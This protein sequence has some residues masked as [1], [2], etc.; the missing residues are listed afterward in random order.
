MTYH[1]CVAA[2]PCRVWR[3]LASTSCYQ[4]N[5]KT[6]TTREPIVFLLLLSALA[7]AQRS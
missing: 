4:R 5:S 6:E 7:V 1:R 2:I 3:R